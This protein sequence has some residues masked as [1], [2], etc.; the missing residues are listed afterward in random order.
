MSYLYVAGFLGLS[1][2]SPI[3]LYQVGKCHMKRELRKNIDE[4][5]KIKENSNEEISA[6][7]EL[8]FKELK[9]IDRGLFDKYAILDNNRE[10]KEN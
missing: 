10:I 1:V 8:H 2:I 7:I 6:L 9:K 5:M 3:V 4:L